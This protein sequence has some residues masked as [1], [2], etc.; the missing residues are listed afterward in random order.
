[1]KK[2][3]NY[4][5]DLQFYWI[6]KERTL[7]SFVTSN[8]CSLFKKLHILGDFLQQPPKDLEIKDERLTGKAVVNALQ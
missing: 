1:M 6:Y 4:L 2:M 5:S 3:K 7:Q 8:A